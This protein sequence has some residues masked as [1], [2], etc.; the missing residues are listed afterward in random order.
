MID[1]EKAL[2]ELMPQATI[3]LAK[4][5]AEGGTTAAAR[6]KRA[7]GPETAMRMVS[8]AKRLLAAGEKTDA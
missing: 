2:L 4:C 1:A 6:L 3:V 5:A 8:E 7:Y